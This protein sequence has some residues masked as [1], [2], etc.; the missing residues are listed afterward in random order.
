MA[1]RPK[2]GMNILPLHEK[3]KEV[4]EGDHNAAILALVLKPTPFH[5]NFH[6]EDG[7]HI[8]AGDGLRNGMN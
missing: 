1:E 5:R 6:R 8:L 2:T 4:D 3:T 7:L